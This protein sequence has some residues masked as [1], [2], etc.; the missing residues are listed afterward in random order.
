MAKCQ[1]IRSQI[2]V[3]RTEQ[4]R[5]TPTF[6]L[7][8][9]LGANPKGSNNSLTGAMWPLRDLPLKSTSATYIRPVYFR[10]LSR[11]T[12]AKSGR[13]SAVLTEQS[14]PNPSDL[15]FSEEGPGNIL[16]DSSR[17]HQNVAPTESG[18][19]ANQPQLIQVSRSN[20]P[21]RYT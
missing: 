6:Q 11:F 1:G 2:K 20:G 10:G 14:G 17:A 19:V 21:L 18:E 7:R 5:Q 15:P 13:G 3:L 8:S 4:H 12:N 16:A 9:C